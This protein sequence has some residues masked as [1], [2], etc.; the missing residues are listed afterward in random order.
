M[1]NSFIKIV[2]ENLKYFYDEIKTNTLLIWGKRDKSTP[3]KDGKYM[4]KHI[5]NSTLIAYPTAAHFSYL[6]CK[7][8]TNQ[9]IEQFLE[10]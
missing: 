10:A 4:K 5:K 7:E 1:Y 3:I 6:E 8:I 2:N 9:I